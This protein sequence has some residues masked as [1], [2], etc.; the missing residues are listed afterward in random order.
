MH[1]LHVV[2]DR[3]NFMKAAPTLWALRA[4]VGHIMAG[5]GSEEAR[6]LCGMA[7]PLIVQPKQ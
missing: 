7:T 2:G 3:P 5:S 6:L 4:E 1:I